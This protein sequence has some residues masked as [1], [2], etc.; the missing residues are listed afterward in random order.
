MERENKAKIASR[1]ADVETLNER[2]YESRLDF[3]KEITALA[4]ANT[5]YARKRD[6]LAAQLKKLEYLRQSPE[7][8]M[9]VEKVAGRK[10]AFG[11]I[12]IIDI[13]LRNDALSNLKDFTITCESRGPSG[14]VTDTNTRVLYEIVDARKTKTFRKLNMG[15]V[16]KQ[17]TK[18]GCRVDAASIA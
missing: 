14:T 3:W 1:L 11:N 8:G 17:A 16:N 2:D 13:T 7:L 18:L 10:E 4:P 9:S 5:E 12:L 6:E 15:F